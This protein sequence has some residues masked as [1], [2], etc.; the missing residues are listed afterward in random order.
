[1]THTSRKPNRFRRPLHGFTLVELLV[2]IGIIALLISILLPSLNAA[3]EAA[4]TVQCASQQ[5]QIAMGVMQYANDNHGFAPVAYDSRY[6]TTSGGYIN[7]RLHSLGYIRT[8]STPGTSGTTGASVYQMYICPTAEIG[9]RTGW[10]SIGY[11][12]LWLFGKDERYY[13]KLS[14]V[15]RSAEACM[16][17]DAYENTYPVNSYAVFATGNWQSLTIYYGYP[18]FRHRG[19]ANVAYC[20]GHV[21]TLAKADFM[22]NFDSG[23]PS[24]SVFWLGK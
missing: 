10:F 7:Q 22:N 20:D 15:K 11:N 1:M 16:W 24:E 23:R 17:V 8:T 5:R 21:G 14:S 19:Y 9:D 12:S 13:T 18:D 2:V 3:R 4:R 6:A